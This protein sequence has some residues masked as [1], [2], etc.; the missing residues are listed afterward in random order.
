MVSEMCAEEVTADHPSTTSFIDSS[1]WMEAIAFLLP[2][3]FFNG[4]K[5]NVAKHRHGYGIYGPESWH[6]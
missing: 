6:V 1:K 5:M 4:E 2:S 3:Q